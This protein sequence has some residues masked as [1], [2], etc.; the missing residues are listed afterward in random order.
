MKQLVLFLFLASIYPILHAQHSPNELVQDLNKTISLYSADNASLFAFL[1][2]TGTLEQ[3]INESTFQ[4]IK[5]ADINHVKVEAN[6]EGGQVTISC[7]ESSKCI[8]LIK[9]DMSSSFNPA[10]T[11]FFS[12]SKAANTFGKSMFELI[13]KYADDKNLVTADL[14]KEIE[15]S[16]AP[17][18]QAPP[19]IKQQ[20]SQKSNLQ[21]SEDEPDDN[22]KV[23]KSNAKTRKQ[24]IIEEEET[25]APAEKVST[26]RSKKRVENNDSEEDQNSAARNNDNPMSRQNVVEIIDPICKQLMNVIKAGK[27]SSF[28]EIEGAETNSTAK[29]NDSKLKLKGAKRSYLSWYKKQRAFIAE[30]KTLTDNELMIEEFQK[31]QTQLEDCLEAGW[32]DIDHSGD[33]MYSKATEEVKDVEYKNVNDPSMPSFRI[34]IGKSEQNKYTLFVRIQ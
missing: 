32:E 13:G 15:P 21:I 14:L 2:Q 17:I 8:N 5:L 3:K 28:K 29:I 10:N 34:L 26:T 22:E 11:F 33:E 4:R 23:S 16:S 1:E 25:E 6:A 31:L 12:D 19:V 24:Q 27:N 18:T 30:F 7:A 20:V 9:K